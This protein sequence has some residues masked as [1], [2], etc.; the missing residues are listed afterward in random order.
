MPYRRVKPDA[1]RDRW[2]HVR[3]DPHHNF[4]RTAQWQR[5]RRAF[6][7]HHPLC[8]HCQLLGHTTP[9]T[10]ADHI[11][12]LVDKDHF[13]RASWAGLQALCAAHH[14]AKSQW[15]RRS[16]CRPLRLGCDPDGYPIELKHGVVETPERLTFLTACPR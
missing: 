14:A 1:P 3:G 12:R 13:R 10:Q 9:A 11:V 8:E 15:E 7:T 2:G 16:Q 4:L 6:L 5:I